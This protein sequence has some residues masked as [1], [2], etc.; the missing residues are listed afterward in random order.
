MKWRQVFLTA[1]FMKMNF[2]MKIL[3]IV[4]F[5]SMVTIIELRTVDIKI[6]L[7]SVVNLGFPVMW[8][9]QEL[10]H[11]QGRIDRQI[12]NHWDTKFPLVI[13]K[14]MLY[15]LGMIHVGTAYCSCFQGCGRLLLN[16][17]VSKCV[18]LCNVLVCLATCNLYKI[19]LSWLNWS[20]CTALC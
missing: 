6:D 2:L 19:A 14:A 17:K 1:T 18:L 7:I 15:W 20:L 9:I 8:W 16:E 3:R 13:L 5:V 4:C 10:W 11:Y 12:F